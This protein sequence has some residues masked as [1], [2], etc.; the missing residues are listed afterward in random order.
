MRIYKWN[1]YK[2]EKHAFCTKD[3]TLFSILCTVEK[4]WY[5]KKHLSSLIIVFSNPNA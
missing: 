1:T 4:F 3:I 5:V 2:N